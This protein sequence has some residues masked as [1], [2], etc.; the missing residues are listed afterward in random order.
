MKRNKIAAALKRVCDYEGIILS[1][2][3]VNL[4]VNR[5]ESENIPSGLSDNVLDEI[6]LDYLQDEKVL[7][8]TR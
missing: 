2:D 4:H 8:V 7:V 5:L 6:V 3:E 1:K